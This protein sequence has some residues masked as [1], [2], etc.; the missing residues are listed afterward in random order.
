MQKI[1][2]KEHWS[3]VVDKYVPT[4]YRVYLH[5]PFEQKDKAK[6][7]GLWWDSEKKLWFIPPYGLKERWTGSTRKHK[8]ECNAPKIYSKD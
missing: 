2:H 4:G 8:H 3:V 7:I 5:V 1:Y 6:A